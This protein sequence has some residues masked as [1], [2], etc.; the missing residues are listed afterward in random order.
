MWGACWA[1]EVRAASGGR[2][3]A[4]APASRLPVSQRVPSKVSEGRER[5]QGGGHHAGPVCWLERGR[6][7]AARCRRPGAAAPGDEQWGHGRRLAVRQQLQPDNQPTHAGRSRRGLLAAALPRLGLAAACNQPGR[8]AKRQPV[9][10]RDGRGAMS[11]PRMWPPWP[12]RPAPLSHAPRPGFSKVKLVT[13]RETGKQYACK[14]IPL[15]RPGKR[16]NEHLSDRGAIMKVRRAAR[17]G[18]PAQAHASTCLA[19]RWVAAG[20]GCNGRGG[21][22]GGS[23]GLL[24]VALGAVRVAGGR[25]CCRLQAMSSAACVPPSKP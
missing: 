13:H 3:A 1:R 12:H 8:S 23:G 5:K 6:R 20:W 10:M 24:Q 18:S 2:Q 7:S 4:L 25:G 11:M 22:V 16:L 17:T 9:S 19:G 15:P 21:W 14:V